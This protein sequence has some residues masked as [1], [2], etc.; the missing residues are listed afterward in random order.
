MK[1]L[2]NLEFSLGPDEWASSY[3]VFLFNEKENTVD[4]FTDGHIRLDMIKAHQL[5][6]WLDKAIEQQVNIHIERQDFMI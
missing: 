1:K 3:S 6:N 5:R 2:E 4:F